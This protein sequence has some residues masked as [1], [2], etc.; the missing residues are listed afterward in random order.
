LPDGREDKA[1]RKAARRFNQNAIYALAV[2]TNGSVVIGGVGVLARLDRRGVPDPVVAATAET[3]RGLGSDPFVV[4]SIALLPNGGILA[5]G[6]INSAGDQPAGNLI[7]LT[8]D[9]RLD[10]AFLKNLGDGFRSVVQR[11]EGVAAMAV[12]PGGRV[13]VVGTFERASGVVQRSIA[14][15]NADGT[16]DRRFPFFAGTGLDFSP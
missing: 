8:P 13:V 4:R 9:G 2:S 15:V 3:L 16:I 14:R 12:V 10:R 11:Q 1:F 5:G 6:A 7:R